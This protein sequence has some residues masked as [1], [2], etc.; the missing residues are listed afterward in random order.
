MTISEVNELASQVIYEKVMNHF[1]CLGALT[2][3]AY[4]RKEDQE[5]GFPTQQSQWP[6]KS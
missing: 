2:K 3:S 5:N 4:E 6:D 1:I